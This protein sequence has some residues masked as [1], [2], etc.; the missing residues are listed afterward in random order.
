MR[1]VTV[2]WKILAQSNNFGFITELT[3]EIGTI[4][5]VTRLID[6]LRVMVRREV[7]AANAPNFDLVNSTPPRKSS[8][9]LLRT[10][11]S[12]LS[13][14]PSSFLRCLAC[15]NEIDIHDHREG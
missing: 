1:N 13:L 9:T 15:T 11:H 10:W 3:H 6:I 12:W 2:P 4:R 7:G 14:I 8:L 5:D